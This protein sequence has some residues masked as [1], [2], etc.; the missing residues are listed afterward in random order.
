MATWLSCF[1]IGVWICVWISYIHGLQDCSNN[2]L[3]MNDTNLRLDQPAWPTK[4]LTWYPLFPWQIIFQD[5]WTISQSMQDFSQSFLQNLN[6]EK[7]RKSL[8]PHLKS[9]FANVRNCGF[10][11]TMKQTNIH[12]LYI[13]LSEACTTQLKNHSSSW[14]VHFRSWTYIDQVLPQKTINF[15][16]WT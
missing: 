14:C 3:W 6:C 4:V 1:L 5:T 15:R 2:S 10:Q 11:L 9:P 7:W 12:I 13:K 16:S 8:Q